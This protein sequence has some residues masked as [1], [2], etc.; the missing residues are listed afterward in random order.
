MSVSDVL[1]CPPV[2][3]AAVCG[4][5]AHTEERVPGGVGRGAVCVGCHG[6]RYMWGLSAFQVAS[7]DRDISWA[8]TGY[9]ICLRGSCQQQQGL[10][11]LEFVTGSW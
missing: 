2:L 3:M 9:L 10:G 6:K 11:P 4:L 8:C 1:S 5:T 7:P